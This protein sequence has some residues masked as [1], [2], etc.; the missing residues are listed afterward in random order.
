MVKNANTPIFYLKKTPAISVRNKRNISMFDY[1]NE[2]N[3]SKM[4]AYTTLT[5]HERKK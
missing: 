1:R 4:T 2:I 5:S 3:I